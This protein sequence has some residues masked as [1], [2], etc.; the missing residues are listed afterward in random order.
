MTL[1]PGIEVEMSSDSEDDT[2]DASSPSRTDRTDH[3]DRTEAARRR[4]MERLHRKPPSDADP[5]PKIE[6]SLNRASSGSGSGRRRSKRLDPL[7]SLTRSSPSVYTDPY[8][9]IRIYGFV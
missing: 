9:R 2:E 4:L 3:T 5:V 1:S 6:S 8:I 7:R